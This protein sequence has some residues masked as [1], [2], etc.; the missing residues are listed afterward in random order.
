MR[1]RLLAVIA[2]PLAG[3]HVPAAPAPWAAGASRPEDLVIRLVTVEPGTPLYSWWGHS[4]IIVEDTRLK[5]ARFYNYGLFSFEKDNFLRNFILGR[6]WFEVG[7]ADARRE[8]AAYRGDNRTIRV[9][10]LNLVPTR[11]LEMAR[12]LEWNILPENRSYLYDHYRDN[13]ATRVRDLIDRMVD[14]QLAVAAAAP[15]RLSLRGHTRRFT[16]GH[17]V[18]NWVLMFL[19]S[20]GIDR[21][22]DRWAEMFL[23]MELERNVADLTYTDP[24]GR[25][26]TLVSAETLFYQARGRVGV[27][28]LPPRYEPPALG[29]GVG[30]ALA[31]L[32]LGFWRNR[33]GRASRAVAGTVEGLTGLAI[34]LIG[35]ILAFMSLF[36][37]HT[38]TYGNRN[39]LLASPL[40]L[41]ALPLGLTLASG[42]RSAGWAGRWLGFL[43]ALLV[44]LSL[45]AIG[46]Q[47]FPA[48]RQDNWL[49]AAL[50]LPVQ[51]AG[52]VNGL[53][54]LA[55]RGFRRRRA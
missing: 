23:P 45:A 40:A 8:L 46:L 9:Q 42:G 41:I 54:G 37:D 24:D 26:R 31:V 10:T 43:W 29:I 18:M 28:A 27:P 55:G 17:A 25:R 36:T 14:G 20:G 53:T 52:A 3:V 39:L 12:F 13:C 19:M 49:A 5:H 2:L 35:A 50:L 1:L 7:A 6:L 30:L 47:A 4:A 22:I 15:G 44:L 34:G 11:R 38:V 21:P 32:A 51:V 16:A 48:L 33:G